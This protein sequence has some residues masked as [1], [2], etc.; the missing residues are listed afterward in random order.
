MPV[1]N[2]VV[3]VVLE[4]GEDC[5][6]LWNKS[7]SYNLFYEYLRETVF[8]CSYGAQVEFFLNKSVENLV[9]VS[10]YYDHA[11]ICT[12]VHSLALSIIS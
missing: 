3:S 5:C 10:L 8:A 1:C 12:S 2:N 6:L 11:F 7:T 4:G 9:T